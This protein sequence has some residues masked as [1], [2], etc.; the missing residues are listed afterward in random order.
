MTNSITMRVDNIDVAEK[1]NMDSWRFFGLMVE[2]TGNPHTGPASKIFTTHAQGLLNSG[3][4]V[5]LYS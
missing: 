2:L 3:G 5:E 4:L 1:F